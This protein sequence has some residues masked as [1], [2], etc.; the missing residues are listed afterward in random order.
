MS[1]AVRFFCLAHTLLDRNSARRPGLRSGSQCR[2]EMP[3]REMVF[4]TA[5]G[6][7]DATSNPGR[8]RTRVVA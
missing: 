2:R 3:T 6:H 5:V 4:Q 8:G 7:C 1:R